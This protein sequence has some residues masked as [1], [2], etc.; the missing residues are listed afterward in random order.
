MVNPSYRLTRGRMNSAYY[1]SIISALAAEDRLPSRTK[2]AYYS[3][4]TP[5][6]HY[7]VFWR[8]LSL[9]PG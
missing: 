7:Y 2:A 4:D 8:Q 1:S 5:L 9:L 3:Q 6:A